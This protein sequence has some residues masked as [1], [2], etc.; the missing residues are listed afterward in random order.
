MDEDYPR[1]LLE[2]ED[3]FR[4]EEACWAYLV[5]LRWPQGFCCPHCSYARTWFLQH[6]LFQCQG[7]EAMAS[8]TGP[9]KEPLWRAFQKRAKLVG[10]LTPEQ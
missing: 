4:T 5:R 7:C 3:R 10:N 1:T 8:V 2:F 9:C 6:R